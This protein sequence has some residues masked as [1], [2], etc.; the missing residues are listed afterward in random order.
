MSR[1]IGSRHLGSAL[2]HL[3]RNEPHDSDSYWMSPEA[4][5]RA[6]LG[7]AIAIGTIIGSAVLNMDFAGDPR[8]EGTDAGAFHCR[9]TWIAALK[10][11]YR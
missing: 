1:R 5:R 6:A 10:T 3:L 8:C 11:S 9:N 2:G 4:S 7:A